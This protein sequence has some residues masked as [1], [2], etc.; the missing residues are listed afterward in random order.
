[1]SNNTKDWEGAIIGIN[2]SGFP[3]PVMYN[4]HTPILNASKDGNVL[5][6]GSTG[7][8]KSHA[9]MTLAMISALEGQQTVIVD[10]KGDEINLTELAYQLDGHMDVW[11]LS[12]KSKKGSMDPFIVQE[13]PTDKVSKATALIQILCGHLTNEQTT[14]LQSFIEDE[15]ASPNPSLSHLMMQLRK[16]GNPDIRVIGSTLRAVKTSNRI[17]NVLFAD[18]DSERTGR[19][20]MNDGLTIITM[21]GMPVPSYGKD[22]NSY[23]PDERLSVGIMYLI[24]DFLYDMMIDEDTSDIPKTI[25]IDEL[26]RVLIT[27]EGRAT[28]NTILR[29]GRSM[30]TACILMTQSVSDLDTVN[31]GGNSQGALLNNISTQFAFRYTDDAETGSKASEIRNLCASLGISYSDYSETI[32]GFAPGECI[33]KDYMGRKSIM[34]FLQQSQEWSDAFETNPK[35]RILIKKR[36]A[37][38]K[39]QA[40]A[41]GA[42]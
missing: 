41:Q 1:M 14:N 26:W 18:P 16:D 23:K 29:T 40:E 11:S 35:K 27:E 10:P 24:M 31:S 38:E 8:G 6:T 12:E 37:A 22:F 4:P 13:K 5:I 33:M 30:N 3:T 36:R 17:S 7:S 42:Y 2:L 9:G 15:A 21:R 28:V 19:R 32:Q 20:K 39:K 34:R 25:L